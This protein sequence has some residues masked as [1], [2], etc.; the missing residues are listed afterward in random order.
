V[1]GGAL[2]N[3]IDRLRFGA[4]VDFIQWHV[5][6]FYWPAFNIADSAICSAPSCWSGINSPQTFASLSDLDGTEYQYLRR[7]PTESCLLGLPAGERHVFARPRRT[8]RAAAALKS[9]R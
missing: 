7:T 9:I 1:L 5:A 3:V 4:V 2:G 6:G 8:D